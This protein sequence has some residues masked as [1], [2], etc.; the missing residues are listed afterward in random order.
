[1]RMYYHFF[2][3]FL[4]QCHHM[5]TILSDIIVFCVVSC[6]SFLVTY[7]DSKMFFLSVIME[8]EEE[9]V[10]EKKRKLRVREINTNRKNTW[11]IPPSIFF[12]FFK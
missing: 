4:Y 3:F 2:P 12:F 10:A 1:M 6:F 8:A 11:R 5:I 7:L 9:E